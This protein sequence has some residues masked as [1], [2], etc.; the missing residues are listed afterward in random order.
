MKKNATELSFSSNWFTL[1]R[2]NSLSASRSLALSLSCSLTRRC[3]SADASLG[4]SCEVIEF[5]N[6]WWVYCAIVAVFQ[7]NCNKWRKNTIKIFIYLVFYFSI[8]NRIH[9]LDSFKMYIFLSLK[10]L[11]RLLIL[12]SVI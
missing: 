2:C 6:S 8:F 7:I 10:E 4:N 11:E 3:S 5:C 9:F 12:Y 1:S